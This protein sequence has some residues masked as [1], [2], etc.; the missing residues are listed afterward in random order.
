MCPDSTIAEPCV[1]QAMETE[2]VARRASALRISARDAAAQQTEVRGLS[3]APNGPA[4]GQ[5]SGAAAR[6]AETRYGEYERNRENL[7]REYGI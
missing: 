1:W 2:P 6:Q 3:G 4:P 7:G 5:R